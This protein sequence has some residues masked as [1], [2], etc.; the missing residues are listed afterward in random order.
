[1]SKHCTNIQII[2][3]NMQDPLFRNNSTRR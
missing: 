3:I 1:L 2:C